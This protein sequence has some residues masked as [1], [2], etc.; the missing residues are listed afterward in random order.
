MRHCFISDEHLGV[1]LAPGAHVSVSLQLR[2]QIG[3]EQVSM[4]D[5]CADK[6]SSTPSFF[7]I[8][9]LRLDGSA[10]L[11]LCDSMHWPHEV[12]MY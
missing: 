10:G 12:E 1:L 5:R 8:G 3:L 6:A 4:E 7:R 9:I 11:S 2:E